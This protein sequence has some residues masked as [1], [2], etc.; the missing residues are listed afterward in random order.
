MCAT[1]R[2]ECVGQREREGE[3]ERDRESRYVTELYRGR[4][5]VINKFLSSIERLN[6]ALSLVVTKY[7]RLVL[8]N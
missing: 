3:R 2:E 4:V 1:F 7:M 6:K 8:A 5:D